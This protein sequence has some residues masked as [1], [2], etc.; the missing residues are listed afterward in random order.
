VYIEIANSETYY[1]FLATVIM[2]K[3]SGRVSGDA[4]KNRI[5]VA[6]L[7]NTPLITAAT[8]VKSTSRSAAASAQPP[9]L[10]FVTENQVR[11]LI[12]LF[13]NTVDQ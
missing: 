11:Y 5:R 13:C 9:P 12:C 3:V 10:F 1:L 2:F 4:E 7:K 6:S 8:F